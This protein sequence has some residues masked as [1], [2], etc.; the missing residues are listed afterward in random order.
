MLYIEEVIR[1]IVYN[2]AWLGDTICK[3][4]S[5]LRPSAFSRTT[6]RVWHLNG[7]YLWRR[8][9]RYIERLQLSPP[10]GNWHICL[11][12]PCVKYQ[13]SLSTVWTS[14]MWQ[15]WSEATTSLTWWSRAARL[16][17]WRTG[18]LIPALRGG[19]STTT[20]EWSNSTGRSDSAPTSGPSAY[21]LQVGAIKGMGKDK[22]DDWINSRYLCLDKI[23]VM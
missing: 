15:S 21:L 16:A 8:A 6:C 9:K 1:F 2:D 22:L 19:A 13:P 17:W 14:C 7:L 10:L 11:S 23:K 5:Y 4:I 3:S 20:S 12:L 18:G